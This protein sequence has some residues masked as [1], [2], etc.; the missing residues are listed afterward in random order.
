MVNRH[1]RPPIAG[2]F[3]FSFNISRET[4]DIEPVFY[5]ASSS[6]PALAA[7]TG[8]PAWVPSLDDIAG[9]VWAVEAQQ[10]R[11][12]L[13]FWTM[14]PA[15]PTRRHPARPRVWG[16][17]VRKTARCQRPGQDGGEDGRITLAVYVGVVAVD[18]LTLP[19]SPGNEDDAP[20]L[21]LHGPD[22]EKLARSW[23]RDE[24]R[25]LGRMSR[26]AERHLAVLSLPTPGSPRAVGLPTDDHGHGDTYDDDSGNHAKEKSEF[27]EG[28][29]ENSVQIISNSVSCVLLF[30]LAVCISLLSPIP[31]PW[32][33]W[34]PWH[35]VV[36]PS[37]PPD[38]LVRLS[39]SITGLTTLGVMGLGTANPAHPIPPEAA[40]PYISKAALYE[41]DALHTDLARLLNGDWDWCP[42]NRPAAGKEEQKPHAKSNRVF[43][44]RDPSDAFYGSLAGAYLSDLETQLGMITQ[45]RTVL[46]SGMREYLHYLAKDA[47]QVLDNTKPI[48]GD[49]TDGNARI[50]I[51]ATGGTQ[52]VPRADFN[53]GPKSLALVRFIT[54][55]V[56]WNHSFLNTIEVFL[57]SLGDT[58]VPDSLEALLCWIVVNGT[59]GSDPRRHGQLGAG[60]GM[61][62]CGS[63]PVAENPAG[64]VSGMH[65]W[66]HTRTGGTGTTG[67]SD[68]EEWRRD[69][70]PWFERWRA[71]ANR[72]ET[73]PLGVCEY[74]TCLLDPSVAY[75]RCE[76]VTIPVGGGGRDGELRIRNSLSA[77]LVPILTRFENIRFSLHQLRTEA[78][79]Q[80]CEP[81]FGDSVGGK[82]P[83]AWLGDSADDVRF[84]CG[85]E[86]GAR[87][88]GKN[89]AKGERRSGREGTQG[90]GAPLQWDAGNAWLPTEAWLAWLEEQIK[91]LEH[92]NGSFI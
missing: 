91:T 86:D 6:Q 7:A 19:S 84:W 76:P 20:V 71:M 28:T 24:R 49:A 79:E 41:L 77:Q 90:Y 36:Q 70:P 18:G 22:L 26:Y 51:R 89:R 2:L 59:Q 64:W 55:S 82:R 87:S 57:P 42:H 80:I 33:W 74:H 52:A 67:D 29:T 48:P 78:R 25:G 54:T 17:V 60:T 39:S 62:G 13:Q 61:P 37:P 66:I 16:F 30:L 92:M 72:R 81:L 4:R 10:K 65:T 56:S 88:E 85:K 11:S 50:R 14:P 5:Q 38:L 58:L 3:A 73:P 43:P 75:P 34:L 83:V 69:L 68:D 1:H 12:S 23:L 15:S 44:C 32:S 8:G 27:G 45:Q 31:L 35:P 21:P 47:R 63:L 46:L 9:H 40:I 53:V